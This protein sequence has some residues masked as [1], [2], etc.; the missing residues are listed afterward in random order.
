MARNLPRHEAVTLIQLRAGNTRLNTFLKCISLRG[1]SLYDC[2]PGPEAVRH[3][4]LYCRQRTDL[5]VDMIARAS[6]RDGDLSYMLGRRSWILDWSG[7]RI[8]G[9]VGNWRPALP[10]VLAPCSCIR[11]WGKDKSSSLGL[12]NPS[13]LQFGA[14]VKNHSVDLS[15]RLIVRVGH[16]SRTLEAG[17]RLPGPHPSG[18]PSR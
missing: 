5:R 8:D 17:N 12:E 7:R 1:D 6:Q 4:L 2:G 15:T 3:Y 9:E 16:V 18:V 13:C 14:T 10:V 11:A